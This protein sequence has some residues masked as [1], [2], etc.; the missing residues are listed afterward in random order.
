M[1]KRDYKAIANDEGRGMN[2]T[3]RAIIE[4]I[5]RKLR[6]KFGCAVQTALGN[7]PEE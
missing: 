1:V 6:A 5:D 2:A 4:A 3:E 7:P